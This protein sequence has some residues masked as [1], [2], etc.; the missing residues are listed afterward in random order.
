MKPQ[1]NTWDEQPADEPQQTDGQEPTAEEG[2]TD[3]AGESDELIQANKTTDMQTVLYFVSY[4]GGFILP[5]VRSITYTEDNYAEVIFRELM[6]GPTDTTTMRS[7]LPAGLEL[8]SPPVISEDRI[9]LSLNKLPSVDDFEDE[10]YE[11]SYAALA[12]TITGF[13]PGITSIDI[14]VLGQPITDFDD[15]YKLTNGM[16]RSDYHGFI[17]SSAP[18]YFTDKNSDLLLVVQHSMEQASTWSAKQRVYLK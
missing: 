9:S 17:G 12:Y 6:A 2:Q 15:S 10:G 7:L 11:A 4:E 8:L 13:L 1:T 18:I 5:E 14:T 3:T 16:Q